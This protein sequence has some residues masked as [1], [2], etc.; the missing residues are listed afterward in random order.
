MVEEGL[1]ARAWA[2]VVVLGDGDYRPFEED[3]SYRAFYWVLGAVLFVAATLW[4]LR[5]LTR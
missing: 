5:R 4:L 3:G 1:P 2:G